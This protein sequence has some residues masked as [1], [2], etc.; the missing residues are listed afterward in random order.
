MSQAGR[1]KRGELREGWQNEGG[2]QRD[3]EEGEKW[4]EGGMKGWVTDV[5]MKRQ[6]E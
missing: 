4:R 6:H 3:Q 5:E 2:M 1:G